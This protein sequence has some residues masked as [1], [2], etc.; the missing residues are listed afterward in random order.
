M[1]L[2]LLKSYAHGRL[3]N[4][5][6]LSGSRRAPRFINSKKNLQMAKCHNPS[7]FYY[8]KIAITFIIL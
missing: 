1:L 3:G 6:F 2:Q 7:P 5:Q 8:N 4:E